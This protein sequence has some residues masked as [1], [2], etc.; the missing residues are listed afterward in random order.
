MPSA[1]FIAFINT[2]SLIGSLT[3][4]P[5]CFRPLGL[6]DIVVS[7]GTRRIPSYDLKMDA[8]RGDVQMAMFETFKALNL[9]GVSSAHG[10]ECINRDT[11]GKAATI[12]GFDLSRDSKPNG[13]YVN[14]DFET[15]NLSISGNFSAA[16]TSSYTSI[17]VL[18][19]SVN[20]KSQFNFL[21][22]L[23]AVHQT[24]IIE[25]NRFLTPICSW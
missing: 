19:S 7:A 14:T 16:T 11:F 4:N 5:Y 22:M 12:F 8:S 9:L 21:V 15:S 10:P 23:F 24:G 25:L 20:V 1:V 17:C 6:S 3:E 2:T 13:P 18:P